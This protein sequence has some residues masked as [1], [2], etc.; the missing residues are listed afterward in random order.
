MA[1]I[2]LYGPNVRIGLA[3]PFAFADWKNPT[4]AEMNARSSTDPHALVYEL[5]CALDEDATTF[6]LGES[7]TDDSKSFCQTA[8]TATPTSYNPEIAF[9]AFR[10]TVPWVIADPATLNTANLAFSLLAWRGVEYFAWMSVGK[11]PGAPF[12]AGD[13][14]KLVRVATDYGIDEI[15][16]GDNV[17]LNQTFASRGDVLW[18][19]EL[20]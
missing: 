13:R 17:R 8:G 3:S 11:E 2:R 7:D 18:N 15:G 20:L 6:D 9:T 16:S 4:L 14:I 1:N 12:V 5:S 10:S 19:H